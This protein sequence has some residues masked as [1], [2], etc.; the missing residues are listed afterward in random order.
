MAKAND[1]A[2]EKLLGYLKSVGIRVDDKTYLTIERA[3]ITNAFHAGKD[4]NYNNAD[5]Y[6]FM[7]YI[8]ND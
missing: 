8:D 5:H 1:T 3:Q 4:G 6:Y 2:V 7:E